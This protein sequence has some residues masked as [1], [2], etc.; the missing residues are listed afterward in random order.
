[1]KAQQANRPELF[2]S[3]NVKLVYFL[4]HVYYLY[5][6]NNLVS[7]NVYLLSCKVSESPS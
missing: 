7:K 6:M 2:K 4:L 3:T 5:F 1:M